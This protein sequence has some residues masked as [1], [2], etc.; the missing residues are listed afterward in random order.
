MKK[1]ALAVSLL[2]SFT[3]GQ[4][5]AGLQGEAQSL[6]HQMLK[7]LE[8]ADVLEKHS[9]IPLTS[10]R[11]FQ[12][13]QEGLVEALSDPYSSYYDPEAYQNLQS[14]TQGVTVGLGIEIAYREQEVIILSVFQD[15][16]AQAA[17]VLPMSKIEAIDGT[18]T[19]KLSWAEI[20]QAL[21]GPAGSK[22]ELSLSHRGQLQK[23]ELQR[24]P[25]NLPSLEFEQLEKDLCY[26]KIRS[27]LREKLHQD[28]EGALQNSNCARGMIL[29]L[30][31]N[32]G[33][34]VNEAVEIAGLL[35]LDGVIVQLS[36]R[37]QEEQ[38]L[39]AQNQGV[40]LIGPIIVLINAG[41][42]SA[43]EVLTGA[44]QDK[45]RAIVMGSPSFGKG[46]VQSILPL[47]NGGGLALTTGNYLTP[48]GRNLNQQGIVPDIK[49]QGTE[50]EVKEKALRDL[51]ESS[52]P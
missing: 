15:S 22:V 3:L 40:Q 4:L 46:L 29:D 31:G 16:P 49:F 7:V 43:A 5:C 10:E 52:S 41:T 11:L 2:V 48:R 14:E 21:Q 35:G 17:G 23:R 45:N 32:P 47:N 18:P 50:S 36:S 44:L 37:N 24:A 30:Q 38:E 34:F 42:A 1:T 20:N 8:I 27:F 13:A 6:S 26:F 9:L 12:G 28:F 51:L 19:Q 25:L 39:T 33:G